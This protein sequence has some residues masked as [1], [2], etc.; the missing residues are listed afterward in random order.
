M[1]CYITIFVLLLFWLLFSGDLKICSHGILF[2]AC[3]VYWS[4]DQYQRSFGCEPLCAMTTSVYSIQPKAHTI[5][6]YI[7]N[8]LSID[9]MTIGLLWWY[10]WYLALEMQLPPA[11]QSLFSI[12][13]GCGYAQN[14]K[15]LIAMPTV[16]GEDCHVE[17]NVAQQR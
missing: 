14:E 6:L 3:L 15:F 11:L 9:S 5:W 16:K 2:V 1:K 4:H 12:H 10:T 7:A 8:R 13:L 17:Y